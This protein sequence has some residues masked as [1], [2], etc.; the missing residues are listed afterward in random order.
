MEKLPYLNV[1]CGAKFHPSW[2]NVDMESSSP[3]VQ[4]HNL[5]KGFPYKDA[6]FEV[7]YHSQVLEHIPKENAES[8]LRECWRVLKPGGILRVVVPDLEGIAR[9][10]LRLVEANSAGS[11]DMLRADYD[12]I[13]LEL[14]DQTVRHWSGGH[15]ETFLVQP[16]IINRNY[17][18][19]RTGRTGALSMQMEGRRRPKDIGTFLS[20][21]RRVTLKR[22]V[23]RGSGLVR[24][25]F[26]TKAAKLGTFRMSGEIHMWMYDRFSLSQL[27]MKAGFEACEIMDP[28]RS[29]IPDWSVYE[30]DVKEGMAYDPTSLF[31][32]ARKPAHAL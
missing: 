21:L 27:L 12:W 20:K 1:G 28:Y 32:E 30:L 31:I 5:L 19:Q 7:I 15:M 3:H 23:S 14:Y 16:R 24:R 4:V 18:L 9:E 11:T 13:M 8:F 25:L 17:V 29:A 6:Q 10:Y 2:A 22:L 26:S